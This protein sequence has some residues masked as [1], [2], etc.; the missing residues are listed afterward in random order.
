MNKTQKE[1]IKELKKAAKKLSK[2]PTRREI[3]KLGYQ[4]YKHF[5]SFNRAKQ[6]AGLSINEKNRSIPKSSYR[7]TKDLAKIVSYLMFDGH[8]YK[9]LTG[10]KAYSKNIKELEKFEKMVKRQFKIKAQYKYNH[11]G[12]KKQTHVIEFFNSK[13]CRF[14]HKIGTPK[15]DKS[16]TKYGVP[17]WIKNNKEFSR[18][19][20][21]IA[22]LC[23]GCW[24]EKDRLNPRIKFNMHKSN[25]ILDNG[26]LFLQDIRNML[27]KF[28]IETTSIGTY[29]GKLRKDKIQTSEL[30]F[31]VLTKDNQK[32]INEIGWFK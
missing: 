2:S 6:L 28:N 16:L 5:S 1:I 21:K 29:K 14:L 30:R 17:L 18:E 23:E 31:R 7:Y 26:R 25:N 12:S 32:F 22:Y 19:Y 4:I 15:G 24:K 11:A 27:R 8:L 10:F 3:P 9:R 13:A 20:L